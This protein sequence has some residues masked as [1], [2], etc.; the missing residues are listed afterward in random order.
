MKDFGAV[1]VIVVSGS[2]NIYDSVLM[3]CLYTDHY[4]FQLE[5][6]KKHMN[7]IMDW[8]GF[9]GKKKISIYEKVEAIQTKYHLV[10]IRLNMVI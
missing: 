7:R 1:I 8:G 9:L 3:N 4:I 6:K 5:I 10:T 2:C